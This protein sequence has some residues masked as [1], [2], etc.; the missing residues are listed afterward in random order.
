MTK[1]N[2]T[3]V[4]EMDLDDGTHTCYCWEVDSHF[5][6]LTQRVNG[7]WDVELL[8]KLPGAQDGYGFGEA[9]ASPAPQTPAVEATLPPSNP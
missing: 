3:P 1:A 7:T 9:T 8:D 5:C 2:W 4:L 6:Y